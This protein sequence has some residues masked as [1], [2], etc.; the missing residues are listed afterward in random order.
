MFFD[1]FGRNWTP[2][3]REP[4]PL[5]S[6]GPEMETQH[7]KPRT[8]NAEDDLMTRAE[9]IVWA[10]GFKGDVTTQE[11]KVYEILKTYNRLDKENETT[12]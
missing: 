10:L 9:N 4:K 3:L 6:Y 7:Q 8:I 12:E 1:W 5:W 2:K 11:K